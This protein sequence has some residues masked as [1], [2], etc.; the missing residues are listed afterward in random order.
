MNSL[1]RFVAQRLA[2]LVLTLFALI[3]DFVVSK[4][5]DR[6]LVWR[7]RTAESETL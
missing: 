3:L 4:V 1:A 6:L 7:P 5:E 2:L